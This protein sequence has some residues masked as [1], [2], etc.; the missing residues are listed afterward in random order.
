MRKNKFLCNIICAPIIAG[1]LLSGCDIL[2]ELGLQ[3][4]ETYIQIEKKP[5]AVGQY[6]ETKLDYGY[7]I[8]K[9]DA[10]KKLYK[11]LEKSVWNISDTI[12][13]DN[14]Y[15]VDEIFLENTKMTKTDII[16][17]MEAFNCD[18]PELFWLSYS[19][20]YNIQGESTYVYLYSQYSSDKVK[21]M[22]NEIKDAV[23]DFFSDI[24]AELSEY[25]RELFVHNKLLTSCVYAD[26]VSTTKDNPTAFSVYGALIDNKAVCEGYT[27]SMQYLL[28]LVGI[29]SISVNGYSKNTLHEWCMVNI[30]DNWYHLDATWND[31]ENK[32]NATDNDTKK[33]DKEKNNTEKQEDT[34]MHTYFNVSDL[35]IKGDHTIADNYSKMSEKELSGTGTQTLFNLPL[36]ECK[37]EALSY[38]NVRGGVL[39]NLDD[40]KSYS[41]IVDNL[42]KVA[43]DKEDYFYLKLNNKLDFKKTT[44]KLFYKDPYQFFDYTDDVNR[45]I[46]T[47]Y[48]ISDSL[49][50]IPFK[51]QSLIVI[52]LAYDKK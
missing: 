30:D 37:S 46:D 9:N 34:V 6:K 29:K 39:K 36:P 32:D 49:S 27:K 23:D 51:E 11:S 38:Y 41:K 3:E 40:Y 8:L 24:P 2:E 21:T 1:L 20:G 16:V 25:D 35:F 42:C 31:R 14:L 19:F 12:G 17:T 43:K 13:E 28:K 15:A 47:D 10:Q 26:G 44:D 45:I 18:N 50:I 48:K 22:Q 5:I 33:N 52:N 7:S 4:K